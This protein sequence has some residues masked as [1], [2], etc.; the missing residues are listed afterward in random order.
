[1]Q[2]QIQYLPT[3]TPMVWALAVSPTAHTIP[4]ILYWLL[5]LNT[6]KEVMMQG[7]W[8]TVGSTMGLFRLFPVYIK[9][10]SFPFQLYHR[11]KQDWAFTLKGTVVS[12][13]ID[14]FKDK[15]IMYLYF[16]LGE[17]VCFECWKKLVSM[18]TLGRMGERAGSSKEKVFPSCSF[19][20]PYP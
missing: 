10:S 17:N 16:I 11:R 20:P 5:A 19:S 8:S 14:Y 3:A 12:A 1:M 18:C 4:L 6:R 13:C 2:S 9:H 7:R 15:F